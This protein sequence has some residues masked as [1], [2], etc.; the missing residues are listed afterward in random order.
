MTD[1]PPTGAVLDAE[2]AEPLTRQDVIDQWI[3]EWPFALATILGFVAL[4]C[5]FAMVTP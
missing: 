1:L 2:I 4:L 3:S 5:V